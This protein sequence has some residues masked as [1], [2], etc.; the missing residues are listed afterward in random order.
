MMKNTIIS[1]ENILLFG[2][3]DAEKITKTFP[4]LLISKY[5]YKLFGWRAADSR[6]VAHNFESIEG[7]NKT[8]IYQYIKNIKIFAVYTNDKTHVLT[9]ADI[10]EMDKIYYNWPPY[11]NDG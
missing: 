2:D 1:A 3:V 5:F 7:E 6:Y 11:K 4:M 10:P 8:L 9:S